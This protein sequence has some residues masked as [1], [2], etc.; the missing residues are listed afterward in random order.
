MR[1]K[2]SVAL[3]VL[4]VAAMLAVGV[5]SAGA[6]SRDESRETLA[7]AWLVTVDRGAAGPL[8][9]LHTYARGGGFV[10]TANA[11]PPAGRGPGHGAWRR[12]GD[13]QFAT[14]ELFFRFDPQ[15]GAFLGYLK[16]RSHVELGHGGDSFTAVTVAQALD[17]NRNPLGPPRTDSATAERIEVEPTS[18]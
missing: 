7:G 10:E 9:S 2:R 5:V 13:R 18:S 8:K 1:P 15:T 3:V 17:A 4:A 12:T 16:L 11:F 6:S 14:T